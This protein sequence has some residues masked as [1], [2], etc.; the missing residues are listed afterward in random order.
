[1]LLQLRPRS[2]QDYLSLPILG[3]IL[4]EFTSWSFQRGYT[5]GTIKS[6]LKDVRKIDNYFVQQGVQSPQLR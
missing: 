5:L 3:S 6:Q 2:Y 4:D 1:M